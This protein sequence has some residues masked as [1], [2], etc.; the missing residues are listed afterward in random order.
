MYSIIHE[1]CQRLIVYIDNQRSD[2]VNA[3][4][5][6]NRF[7]AEVISNCIFGL[8]AQA[9]QDRDIF[10]TNAENCFAPTIKTNILFKL[11]GVFPFLRKFIANPYATP[12]LDEWFLSLTKQAIEVRKQN[13]VSRDDYFNFI[14]DLKEKKN[15]TDEEASGHIFTFFLDGFET[16]S[17]FI[18]YAISELA[19][20]KNVQEKLRIEANSVENV[21]WDQINQLPYLDNVFN[22][23]LNCFSIDL[24][25]F[26]SFS[27]LVSTEIL[28]H[29]PFPFPLW[30]K[31]TEDIEIEDF[32]ATKLQVKKG[33]IVHVPVYSFHHHP[34]YYTDVDTFWPE[35][36]DEFND[37]LKKLK[38]VGAFM[39]F[40]NG[41]R[42]CLGKRFIPVSCFQD[43]TY[44]SSLSGMRFATT[45]IKAAIFTIVKHFE[46][47][48]DKT[49]KKIDKIANP[50]QFPDNQ[51]AVHFNRLK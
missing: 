36:F 45:Q 43:I 30:K 42:V 47:L 22:G 28:R 1:I 32:D 50:L 3:R 6:S 51:T 8:E 29:S 35:R 4:D 14:F 10:L 12:E 34:G 27:S 16:S 7:T 46:V 15:L 49:S 21:D 39:P 37:D 24:G 41:P 13:G 26:L 40:G 20:N 48:E 2:L 33:E 11:F 31:C 25:Y 9:F 38:D 18:A 5:L 44:S 17:H 19:K 23:K